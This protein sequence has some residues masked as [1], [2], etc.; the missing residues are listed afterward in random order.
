MINKRI[1]QFDYLKAIAILAVITT[2]ITF[3]FDVTKTVLFPFFID[4]AVPIFMIISGYVNACSFDKNQ[5]VRECYSKSVMGR[6]IL[7]I[8]IPY[9]LF[10]ILEVIGHKLYNIPFS[11]TELLYG[12]LTGGWGKGSY[13]IFLQL[14]LLLIFPILLQF[15]RK[16]S[17][18][19]VGILILIQMI[20]QW[21]IAVGRFEEFYRLCLLRCLIFVIAGILL[22][23]Y[24]DRIKIRHLFLLGIIGLLLIA[25]VSYDSVTHVLFPFRRNT[26]MPTVV[27]ASFLVC[28]SYQKLKR[29]PEVVDKCI[30]KIGQSSLWILLVQIL[31]YRFLHHVQVAIENEVLRVIVNCVVCC[32]I[33]ILFKEIENLQ[34][35]K[36]ANRFIAFSECNV[37]TV[38]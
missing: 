2:H 8:G 30:M 33:G 15:L 12:F 1:Y 16:T 22:Y 4:M 17:W 7:A 36:V 21:V 23:W 35:R 26:S 24:M 31:Y 20:Y 32:S 5:S 28:I 27:W 3:S 38:N 11:T 25:W 14:Q 37:E 13:Y 10:F 19:G 9:I 6:K 34:K 29:L 18:W